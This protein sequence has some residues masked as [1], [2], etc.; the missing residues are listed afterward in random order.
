MFKDG[1]KMTDNVKAQVNCAFCGA[2]VKD[3]EN[4][5]CEQKTAAE[6]QSKEGSG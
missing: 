2:L 6:K 3:G 1:M 4:H 5:Q